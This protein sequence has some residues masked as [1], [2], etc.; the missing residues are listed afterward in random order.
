MQDLASCDYFRTP[1]IFQVP[2]IYVFVGVTSLFC[3]HEKLVIYKVT[4][5]ISI[6]AHLLYGEPR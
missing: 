1:V 6:Q 2:D 4:F 5:M 3:S